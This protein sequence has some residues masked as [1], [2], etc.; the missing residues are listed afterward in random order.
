M[1]LIVTLW[2]Q[3]CRFLDR[4]VFKLTHRSQVTHICVSKLSIIASYN[5]LSPGRRQAI[6]WTNDGIGSIWS[7]GTNFDE[8]S[9]IH[10]FSFQ[11]M[12]LKMSSSVWW[13]FCLSL[14]VLNAVFLLEA[15]KTST[16]NSRYLALDGSQN[17]RARV[18]WFSRYLALSRIQ[19]HRPTL[20]GVYNS[21]VCWAIIEVLTFPGSLHTSTSH[22]RQITTSN[23]RF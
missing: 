1:V 22:Q 11:K 5:R 15:C 17:S 21:Q 9:Y 8:I 4:Q 12:H 19:D 6:I 13:P 3:L 14:N 7:L 23:I 16:V 18:K 2:Q 10:T 20:P